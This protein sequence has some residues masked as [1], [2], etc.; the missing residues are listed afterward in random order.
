MIHLLADAHCDPPPMFL[1][2]L[3]SSGLAV[4]LLLLFS[5]H[6]TRVPSVNADAELLL[7]PIDVHIEACTRARRADMCS[8]TSA[9]HISL[10]SYFVPR[11]QIL[12]MA[13]A[14]GFTGQRCTDYQ[15]LWD[16]F[17]PDATIAPLLLLSKFQ[18]PLV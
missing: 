2:S 5:S 13:E 16:E 17:A 11:R 15:Q 6:P 10:N 8:G 3:A 7:C 1:L 18:S 9:S 4:P 14:L 12:G